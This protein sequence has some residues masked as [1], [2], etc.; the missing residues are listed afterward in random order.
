MCFGGLYRSQ[1]CALPTDGNRRAIRHPQKRQQVS[2]APA[3]V[4]DAGGVGPRECRERRAPIFEEPMK[5]RKR[6]Q[7]QAW[8]EPSLDRY[9]HPLWFDFRNRSKSESLK[10]VSFGFPRGPFALP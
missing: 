9:F 1:R 5:L 3:S 8:A 4:S 2:R 7:T 10:H 6:S